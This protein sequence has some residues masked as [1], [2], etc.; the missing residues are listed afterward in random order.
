MTTTEAVD[1]VTAVKDWL[2][3]NWDPELTVGE[4]WDRLG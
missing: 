2:S 4:W 3:A 1:A